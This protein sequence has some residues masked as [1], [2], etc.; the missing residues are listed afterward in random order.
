MLGASKYAARCVFDASCI[1]L[2]SNSCCSAPASAMR[3]FQYPFAGTGAEGTGARIKISP[4]AALHNSAMSWNERLSAHERVQYLPVPEP[5]NSIRLPIITSRHF[6][7]GQVRRSQSQAGW[8]GCDCFHWDRLNTGA[9]WTVYLF[10]LAPISLALFDN[11]HTA[12]PKIRTQVIPADSHDFIAPR[13][14]GVLGIAA[15]FY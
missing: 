5:D 7:L 3:R 9:A 12:R 11:R 8:P 15:G 4:Y 14:S 13:L 6:G 10:R 1:R 2:Y